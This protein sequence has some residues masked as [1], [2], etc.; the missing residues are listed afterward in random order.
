MSEE[1]VAGQVSRQSF[2]LSSP[3]SSYSSVFPSSSSS[4]VPLHPPPGSGEVQLGLQQ[5]VLY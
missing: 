3:L 1:E 4:A 2:L 5:G